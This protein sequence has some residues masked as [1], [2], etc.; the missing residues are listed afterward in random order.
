MRLGADGLLGEDGA[1]HR[2]ALS[3]P[4]APTVE[5]S[6]TSEPVQHVIHEGETELPDGEP[7]L[8]ADELKALL[9]EQPTLPPDVET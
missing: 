8:T 7:V 5:P 3:L 6:A 4:V 9:H 1:L 2:M